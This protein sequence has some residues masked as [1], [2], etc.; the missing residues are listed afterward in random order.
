MKPYKIL[1]RTGIISRPDTLGDK[2]NLR[3][4][5]ITTNYAPHA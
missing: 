2:Y 4:P 5:T 3:P 1:R